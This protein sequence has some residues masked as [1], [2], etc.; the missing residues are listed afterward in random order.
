MKNFFVRFFNI[1][2]IF[3]AF[4][5]NPCTHQKTIKKYANPEDDFKNLAQD[6]QNVGDYM[7][8][9]M[10]YIDE[11]IY[12]DEKI[13]YVDFG[14]KENAPILQEDKWIPANDLDPKKF[15]EFLIACEKNGILVDILQDGSV[16]CRNDRSLFAYAELKDNEKNDK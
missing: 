8:T 6:W 13:K 15:E 11:Q 12:D 16:Y 2:N 14:L 1:F 10:G 3:S 4:N 7:R 9:A 5:P